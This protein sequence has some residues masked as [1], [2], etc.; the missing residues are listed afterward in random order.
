MCEDVRVGLL[1]IAGHIDRDS[2]NLVAA[3]KQ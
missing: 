2:L 3:S 1:K